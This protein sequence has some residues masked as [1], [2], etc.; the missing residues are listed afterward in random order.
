MDRQD[1]IYRIIG[2]LENAIDMMQTTSS[3]CKAD[4]KAE[5]EKLQ[6]LIDKLKEEL[7]EHKD[8][9]NAKR[10]KMNKKIYISWAIG[11]IALITCIYLAKE[12][13][14]VLTFLQTILDIIF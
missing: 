7:E 9:D 6:K 1:D 14:E 13:Q 12:N 3:S 10:K 11:G 8:S 5:V 2:K 4:R